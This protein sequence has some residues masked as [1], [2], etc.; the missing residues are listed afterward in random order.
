MTIKEFQVSLGK[1]INNLKTFTKPLK[2]AAYTATAQMGE[3]IFDNGKKTDESDISKK[4]SV[5]PVY[6]SKSAVPSPKGAPTGKPSGKKRTK[7]TFKFNSELSSSGTI[8]KEQV[9]IGGKSKF[10]NGKPHKSKYF[11]TGYKGYREN[12]GRQTEFVDLSLSGE[13][14]QDFSNGKQVATP[15]KISDIE[16]QIILNKEIDQL[17]RGG[18]EKKYGEIFTISEQEKEL[19]FKTIDFE[20]RKAMSAK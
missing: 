12:V 1:R 13:L 19:F 18:L 20:F 6:I 5:K 14:R 17:K 3:R 15:T 11:V 7:K 8:V 10:K 2:L 16:Y 9:D 4:Y